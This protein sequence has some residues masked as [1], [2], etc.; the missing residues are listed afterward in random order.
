M[1]QAARS[2]RS[3]TQILAAALRLF[4]SQGYRGTNM[5]E[6]AEAA[7]VST[8]NVYHQFEDKEA[9]FR[10]L[11]DEYATI[12][13]SPTYPFNKA[14]AEGLFPRDLFKLGEA[15]RESLLQT[16]AH[17]LLT[18]VD[19][20]EFEGKHLRRFYEDST[21]RFEAHLRTPIGQQLAGQL[22]EGVTP[23]AALQVGT[24]ILF[25]Y[26][27]TEVL[28]GVSNSFGRDTA[29]VMNEV[30]DLLTRGLLPCK[31]A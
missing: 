16:R 20:L 12:V 24:R 14:I 9:I 13:A 5:R 10:T 27:V 15:I 2:E 22:R 4:S 11:L 28:F 8:G 31:K 1:K 26:F 18:Y 21:S 17:A 29:Q 25:N 6:I 7:G 3:R 23:L 19:V 30:T